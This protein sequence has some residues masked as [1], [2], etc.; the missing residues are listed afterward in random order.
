MKAV[1]LL[2]GLLFGV[3]AIASLFGGLSEIEG[4][5][6]SSRGLA[7]VAASVAALGFW[8]VM[9]AWCFQSALRKGA[10]S[11]EE[12]ETQDAA[13][14]EPQSPDSTGRLGE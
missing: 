12:S 11:T 9:S 10:A 5:L 14:N 3:C 8:V 13:I 4:S 7:D 6:S 1:K 2:F